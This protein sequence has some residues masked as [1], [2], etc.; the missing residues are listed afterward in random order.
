M[1]D[2]RRTPGAN[3]EASGGRARNPTEF[4]DRVVGEAESVAASYREAGWDAT[5][6]HP[7]ETTPVPAMG[8][9]GADEYGLS[10]LVPPG[11][12]ETVVEIEERTT[13]GE[14][15]IRL[16]GRGET[17]SLVVAF[18]A[19]DAGRAVVV[20]AY[21]GRGEAAPMLDRASAAGEMRV[22][23]R[24]PDDGPVVLRHDD[25]GAWTPGEK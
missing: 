19:S 6:L 7:G 15:D 5:A 14:V 13:L 21:Y 24:S 1:D 10:V 3:R 16:V 22:L 20:P 12:F 2:S 18:R 23:V 4:W 8:G 17:V 25:P 11:E 9:G